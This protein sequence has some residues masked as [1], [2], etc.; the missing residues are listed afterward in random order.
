[1]SASFRPWFDAW[2][3]GRPG[4]GFVLMSERE[5]A[6]RGAVEGDVWP[7]HARGSC[8]GAGGD[9]TPRTPVAAA[10]ANWWR[11]SSGA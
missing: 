8:C 6:Y 7:L 1:M 2:A 5:M 3:F 11:H 4:M 10:A 9:A